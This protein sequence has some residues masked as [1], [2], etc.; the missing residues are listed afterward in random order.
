M[1]NIKSSDPRKPKIVAAFKE[2][3]GCTKVTNLKESKGRYQAHCM[4]KRP[5]ERSFESLGDRELPV[6]DVTLDQ[7]RQR[8][9]LRV[10]TPPYRGRRGA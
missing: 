6:G 4:V 5:G 8:R 9:R 10:H 2:T 3:F 7:A 1:P